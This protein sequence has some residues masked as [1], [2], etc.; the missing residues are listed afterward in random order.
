MGYIQFGAAI[1]FAVAA[2]VGT[3][4]VGML[5]VAVVLAVVL[6][7][8]GMAFAFVFGKEDDDE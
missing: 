8:I 6:A 7:L 5:V 3:F 2:G 1:G 4:A